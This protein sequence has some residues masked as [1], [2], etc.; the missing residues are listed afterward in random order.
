MLRASR[1]PGF[2]TREL[3]AF[4]SVGP[5]ERGAGRKGSRRGRALPEYGTPNFPK[6]FFV[7]SRAQ[8]PMCPV[9]LQLS[10]PDA[11]FD[12]V[13]ISYGGRR[14][15]IA[16]YPWPCYV[17]VGLGSS[18]CLVSALLNPPSGQIYN[19]NERISSI[20]GIDCL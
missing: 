4:V 9:D 20:F 13:L 6:A 8:M 10:I 5:E 17:C 3:F 11:E 16:G 2:L 7:P 12:V 14:A 15:E 19:V 1:N 18:G